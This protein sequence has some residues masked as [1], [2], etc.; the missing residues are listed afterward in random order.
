MSNDAFDRFYNEFKDWS[1]ENILRRVYDIIL[2]DVDKTRQIEQLEKE[3]KKY[4]D[5][6]FEHLQK[7]NNRLSNIINEL[8]EDLIEDIKINDGLIMCGLSSNSEREESKK[9]NNIYY[10]MLNKLQKLKENNK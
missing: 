6:G 8:E 9:E 3:N 5:L 7:E 1:K 4:K 10:N 2:D